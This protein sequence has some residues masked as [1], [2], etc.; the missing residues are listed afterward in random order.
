MP[1]PAFLVMGAMFSAEKY[2]M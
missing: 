1:F 2:K